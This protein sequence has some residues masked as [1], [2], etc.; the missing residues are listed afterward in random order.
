MTKEEFMELIEGFENEPFIITIGREKTSPLKYVKVLSD[1]VKVM[2]NGKPAVYKFNDM[3]GVSFDIQTDNDIVR[4]NSYTQNELGNNK[5]IILYEFPFCDRHESIRSNLFETILEKEWNRTQNIIKDARKNHVLPEKARM[6]VTTL[7]MLIMD[8][9]CVELY[10][11]LGETYSYVDDWENAC[12]SFEKAGDYQNAAYFAQKCQKGSQER[13]FTVLGEW[14][15]SQLELDEKV[16]SSFFLLTK[17]LHK[18]RDCYEV[19]K[20]INLTKQ[21]NSVQTIVYYGLLDVLSDYRTDFQPDC[22]NGSVIAQIN[23]LL[24]ILKVETSNEPYTSISAVNI[25]HAS[26]LFEEE[27]VEQKAYDSSFSV[28]YIIKASEHFG[29]IGKDKNSQNG[30]YFSKDD[31]DSPELSKIYSGYNTSLQGIKVSYVPA[32][33][34]FYGKITDVAKSVQPLEN[35]TDFLSSKGINIISSKKISN[36]Q[37]EELKENPDGTYSGYIIKFNETFGFIAKDPDQTHGVFFYLNAL[38][39]QLLTIKNHL[40]GL[41]VKCELVEKDHPIKGKQKNA[42]KI[43]ADEDIDEFMK[44]ILPKTSENEVVDDN[45]IERELRDNISPSAVV[46]KFATS[47]KPLHALFALEKSKDTFTYDKY[48]KHKI[49]LLQRTKT[50]DNELIKLLNYTITTS[51]DGSYVAHNLFFLGQVYF[52]NKQ[53]DSVIKTMNSLQSYRNDMKVPTMYPDSLYYIAISYYMLKDYIHSDSYARKLQNMNAHLEDMRKLLERTFASE[54]SGYID[55]LDETD[56]ELLWQ[57]DTEVKLTPF[58]EQLISDFSFGLISLEGIPSDFDPE[59]DN[60]EL[61]QAEGYIGKLK[62]YNKNLSQRN[63]PNA[64]IAMAKIEKWIAQNS[65]EN[66]KEEKEN[67]LRNNISNALQIMARKEMGQIRVHLFYRMQQYEMSVQSGKTELFNAYVNA[68][69]GIFDMIDRKSLKISDGIKEKNYLLMVSDVLLLQSAV[70]QGE[71]EKKQMQKLCNILDSRHDKN[72]YCEALHNIIN[73]ILPQQDVCNINTIAMWEQAIMAMTAWLRTFKKD[74]RDKVD[75]KQ[76]ND[77]IVSLKSYA[78]TPFLTKNEN[79]FIENVYRIVEYINSSEQNTQTAVKQNLLNQSLNLSDEIIEDLKNKPT[80]ITYCIFTDI[81][82]ILKNTIMDMLCEVMS[83]RPDI[84]TFSNRQ[85]NLGL[86]DMREFILPLEFQN[87]FPA[88]QAQNMTIKVEKLSQGV[89]LRSELP[90]GHNI[91][92][93]EKYSQSLKFRLN[94]PEIEQ[95]NISIRVDYYYDT[96]DRI[97]RNTERIPDFQIFEYTIS[98]Q[99]VPTIENKYRNYV[100]QQTVKDKSMFFGRDQTIQQIFDAITVHDKNGICSLRGGNGFVL[101]G[102][103]RSG[104]TSILYHIK[105]KIENETYYTIVVDMGD[106]RKV[107]YEGTETDDEKKLQEY[108]SMMTLYSFYN[109]IIDAIKNNILSKKG[110]QHEFDEL[111]R[112]IKDYEVETSVNVFPSDDEFEKSKNYQALFNRFLNAFSSIIKS[113]DSLKKFKVVIL[114]DEF[115]AYNTA[116]QKNKTLPN[117]FMSIMKGIVADTLITL[118]VAGQDNMIEFIDSYV[119]EFMSFDQKWVTFLSEEASKRMIMDPIGENRIDADAAHKLYTFTAGSPFFLMSVC[120]KLVDWMNE[121]KIL[122]LSGSLPDDFLVRYMMDFEFQEKN[123]EPLYVDAGRLD[124]TSDIK[125]VLGLIARGTSKTVLPNLVP[126]DEYNDYATVTDDILEN[127][128]ISTDRMCEILE[129]LKNREV[130]EKMDGNQNKYRI[131]IPL[132]REWILR[133]GGSAYGN[134]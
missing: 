22:E 32:K 130:I 41:K 63:N 102:Q 47:G 86:T 70:E 89:E 17:K 25:R 13:L 108:N 57:F 117:N 107:L 51:Q 116:I 121:N 36:Y 37:S 6:V 54:E 96:F 67:S 45:E 105:E 68:H 94:M 71:E 66:Q 55:N 129:R 16:Y 33:S 85:I 119:N 76:W 84:V 12:S 134:K 127:K 126:W 133:R 80:Y 103:R 72:F 128:G 100:K 2:S 79:K 112:K 43:E 8:Y 64:Y 98:F 123:L 114:I 65:S 61:E 110:K 46:Q 50:D 93:G 58:I 44:R 59:S 56:V 40:P 73:H 124:W 111:F 28:G 109:G 74:I 7:K 97:K 77:L 122:K 91:N 53:Y 4:T 18:C 132:C 62:K 24:E 15:V 106:T 29:F 49:Q 21:P 90:N 60:V 38:S 11:L 69:Y 131:K 78:Y 99:D 23:Q 34:V 101:Y 31:I 113:D 92:E 30:I 26:E 75:A 83:H 1:S 95:I 19:I 88:I 118:I 10:Q 27:K 35:L 52:R 5:H 9:P 82:Q 3:S 42:V 115:T 20:E 81:L 120:S 104:K 14:I 48:V 39:S 87:I 125:M